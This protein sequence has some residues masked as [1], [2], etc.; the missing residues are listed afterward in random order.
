MQFNN[1]HITSCY[2]NSILNNP[3]KALL[4]WFTDKDSKLTIMPIRFKDN[5]FSSI[6]FERLMTLNYHMN[7]ERKNMRRNGELFL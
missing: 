6:L 3:I 4:D 5:K 7:C 1:K 2:S